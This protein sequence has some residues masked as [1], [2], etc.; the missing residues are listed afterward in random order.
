MSNTIRARKPLSS[1]WPAADPFLFCAFH[2]DA[3]PASD[4]A[5]GVPRRCVFPVLRRWAS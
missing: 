3:Y 4:G 1:P 5:Q 2:L